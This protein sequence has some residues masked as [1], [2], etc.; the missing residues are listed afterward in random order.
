MEICDI[1]ARNMLSG[2]VDYRVRNNMIL[3][4]LKICFLF[5]KFFF[6]FEAMEYENRPLNN[7]EIINGICLG[8]RFKTSYFP[9]TLDIVPPST[10]GLEPK[11]LLEN[12]SY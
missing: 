7:K 9:S 6:N 4:I 10:L 12:S 11:F 2:D 8:I 1:D 3:S 5:Y